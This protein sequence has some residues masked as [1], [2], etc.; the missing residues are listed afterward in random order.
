MYEQLPLSD[1]VALCFLSVD[2]DLLLSVALSGFV[3]MWGHARQENISYVGA[4][5]KTDN[6]AS[7]FMCLM[8][9]REGFMV[10]SSS[11]VIY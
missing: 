9:R 3:F 5:Y 4:H 2:T 10:C 6:S 1:S 8:T 11:K 7:V